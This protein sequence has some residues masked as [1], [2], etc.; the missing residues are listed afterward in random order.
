MINR[1]SNLDVIGIDL[2]KDYKGPRGMSRLV[3]ELTRRYDVKA[4]VDLHDVLRT[5]MMGLFMRL[6]GV[7]VSTIDKGRRDKKRLVNVGAEAFGR[8]LKPTSARYRDAIERAGYRLESH[9][10]TLFP[11][12]KR[13]VS[14]SRIGIAPFAA[15]AG[16]IYPTD[17]LYSVVKL[18]A[19][20]TDNE[21]YLFGAGDDENAILTQWA[22]RFD[23][24]TNLAAERRGLAE[25][26]RLMSTLD[27]MVA[28]DSGNMHLASVA[29]TPRVISIWGQTHPAAGFIPWHADPADYVQVEMSCRPC[30][31]FGNRPCKHGD[32][33]CLND[34]TVQTLYKKIKTT[35]I[36]LQTEDD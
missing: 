22:T 18:L 11:D 1:P 19:E 35:L 7:R 10:T 21:I 25:E 9:F 23:N 20:D 12:A 13:P 24:V 17:K 2:K 31:V 16:K 5:R 32:Y 27:V 33:P 36:P 26:L 15:H 34:I 4:F 8:D 29:G 6:Y 3:G 14:S 30:S 28:M